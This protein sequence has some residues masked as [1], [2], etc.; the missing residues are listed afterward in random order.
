MATSNNS[1]SS[2][3]SSGNGAKKP[4]G[5]IIYAGLTRGAAGAVILLS[6]GIVLSL[7][8]NSWPAIV[9][10]G[11]SFISSTT[12]NP[13]MSEFGALSSIA[14]TL[15]STIIAMA[16]AVPLAV[17]IAF[18][19]VELAHPVISKPVGYA[20]ELLA[21]VPSIIYGM[22][23]LFVFAPFMADYIQPAL[24]RWFGF[25]PF[26]EGP[27]MGIGMLSAGIILALMVLPFIT[28]VMRDVFQMVPSVVKEASYGMGST[29]L[30]VAREV[31][32]KYGFSGLIG[33]VFLGLG[34]AVGE[35]MAVTFVIGNSHDISVS[36]YAAGNTIAS[37]LANEF[38]EAA[39]PMY[40]S[41]LI[42]LGL[43]LFLMTLVIQVLAQ[44]WIAR[45]QKK[46]GA[47]L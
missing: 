33:A 7:A 23:G 28:A 5:D 3:G 6:I 41:A 20:I 35:T 17:I 29:T 16:I 14:G 22:W 37:T 8:G 36:L 4:L 27:P 9:K 18:F 2:S 46:A 24:Q 45:T 32:V 30:E 11:A 12:W 34:R 21:A 47:G 43:V 44:W 1:S 25:L 42:E 19:L 40:I 10:F 26:F 31:T 13:V 15:I 39:E 38:T